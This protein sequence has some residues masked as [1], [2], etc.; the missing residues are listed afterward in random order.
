MED[1]QMECHADEI[2]REERGS[3]LESLAHVYADKGKDFTTPEY[4]RQDD[5]WYKMDKKAGKK[6]GICA[7]IKVKSPDTQ[8]Q[9]G[10]E[11]DAKTIES[12]FG[13]VIGFDVKVYDVPT[14]ADIRE[15]LKTCKDDI[16][17]DSST[18]SDCFACF[19]LGH[20]K[21]DITFPFGGELID[22]EYIYEQFSNKV[23]TK[24]LGKPKLFFLHTL[25]GG[26]QG[27]KF[28][29][30]DG[31]SKT[32]SVPSHA[33]FFIFESTSTGYLS[34]PGS[35]G[36]SLF[37]QAL[38]QVINRDYLTK[39]FEEMM[40]LV[41]YYVAREKKP[42][43]TL[44]R[45]STLRKNIRFA[46]E[47]DKMGDELSRTQPCRAPAHSEQRT[48]S[49]GM[50]SALDS[51]AYPVIVRPSHNPDCFELR[52]DNLERLLTN[53]D[54]AD[55]PVVVL[56]VAGGFRLGKSF[57]L[58]FCIRYLEHL[59]MSSYPSGWMDKD[60]I[61]LTG[62]SWKYGSKR[63][64]TGIH[65]WGKVFKI[66]TPKHGLVAVVLMDTE[67]AFDNTSTLEGNVTIFSV[68][69]LL[70]SVQ[71]Y[72]LTKQITQSDLEHLK[73]F[74]EYASMA[75]SKE[76]QGN[77]VFQKLLFLIRDWKYPGEKPFGLEGGQELLDPWLERNHTLPREVYELR[78]NIISSF[79]EVRCFL[80]PRPG[81]AIEK[82]SFDGKLHDLST[83]FKFHIKDLVPFLLSPETV[84]PKK[85]N[86][87]IVTCK[88]LVCMFQA[89]F[90]VFNHKE[91][92][93]P[94]SIFNATAFIHNKRIMDKIVG[95][96]DT[97]MEAIVH[98]HSDTDIQMEHDRLTRECLSVFQNEQKMGKHDAEL[99]ELLI[100]DLND[101][102][103]VWRHA[104]DMWRKYTHDKEHRFG[105]EREK[106]KR[107][108]QE[109]LEKLMEEER[110]KYQENMDSMARRHSLDMEQ[111][112]KAMQTASLKN[113]IWDIGLTI[114]NTFPGLCQ[115]GVGLF[116]T[117]LKYR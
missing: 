61:P 32:T 77:E 92:P 106:P 36:G 3:R 112:R 58:G 30:A 60:D 98:S 12:V 54:V 46:A 51:G 67:G 95:K 81:D 59:E 84:V 31:P 70:S 49:Q 17:K 39:N 15:K 78:E 52:N 8:E 68:S 85:I 20:G 50:D 111:M 64:T 89:Y 28:D 83:D 102:Y 18:A 105:E 57:L 47:E 22:L 53:P 10:A 34:S 90:S 116:K 42:D 88:E 104:R 66:K 117:Y 103:D 41:K 9:S 86:G 73:L 82:S 97:G 16:D 62:F 44:Y 91:L 94:L 69:M 19:V 114:A 1:K 79:A 56:S 113:R 6:C 109:S 99:R 35:V 5:I 76:G 72:N 37:V 21:E 45:H 38:C 75:R 33:D 43:E 55:L 13:G 14:P 23:C 2:P 7:I 80:L 25:R 96:Y 29:F 40:T 27:G 100:K 26:K 87:R 4:Y 101:H 108:F 48:H 24:L 115:A 93:Q 65:L 110:K 74:A 11:A 63:H 71:V 107:D